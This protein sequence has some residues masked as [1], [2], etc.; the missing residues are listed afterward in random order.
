MRNTV[1]VHGTFLSK[2]TPTI[3]YPDTSFTPMQVVEPLIS[4][5]HLV[6][7]R[8]DLSSNVFISLITIRILGFCWSNTNSGSIERIQFTRL[9]SPFACGMEMK[10]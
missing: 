4:S 2:T 9:N 10:T 1:G 3:L 7:L 6:G 5:L 8:L